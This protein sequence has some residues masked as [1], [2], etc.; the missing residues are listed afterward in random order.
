[1][2]SSS[3]RSESAW[4]ARS[5]RTRL[6]AVLSGVPSPIDP[7]LAWMNDTNEA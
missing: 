1:M 3:S 7:P 5:S 6:D 2:A 4:R